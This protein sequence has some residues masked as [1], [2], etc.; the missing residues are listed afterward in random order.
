M[1]KT[2]KNIGELDRSLDLLNSI[3]DMAEIGGWELDTSNGQLFWT[4]GVYNIYGIPHGTP[5]DKFDGLSFYAEHDRPRITECVRLCMEEG[6][7]YD[8]EFD[9]INQQGE[10]L[11]V[12]AMGRPIYDENQNIVFLRGSFQDITETRRREKELKDSHRFLKSIEDNAAHALISGGIDGIILS[13]SKA[14]EEMLGYSA[15]EMIGIQTPA[16]FH[17]LDE[18]VSRSIEFSKKLGRKIEPGFETFICHSD[19]GLKNQFEWTYIHKDGTKFPVNL[20]ITILRDE[21]NRKIGY[22]G[23]AEDLREK[24]KLENDLEEE[25]LKLLQSSKLATLGEMAAGVAHEINNPLM[26]ISGCINVLRKSDLSET[27]KNKNIEMLMKSIKRITKIVKGLKKFSRAKDDITLEE[28]KVVAL[29]EECLTL[30][31][32]KSK[33]HEVPVKSTIDQEVT[34]FI[35][36]V[37]LEQI[38]VNLIG[39]AI[40]ANTGCPDP[41]VE[42][43][44][45]RTQSFD[46]IIVIDSGKGVEKEHLDKLY[47]PFFTTKEIGKGTGLGLSISS[48]IAKDHGGKLEYQF[49]DGHT[50]FVLSLPIYQAK[51]KIA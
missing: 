33:R 37:H 15:D 29:V 35:D 1:K 5:M 45:N 48:G 12:R 38:L 34:L 42:L 28:I 9:F 14:A 23:I 51:K 31:E 25:R 21:D 8:Q 50:A 40:D 41:W 3:Q 44:Y 46:Q 6:L 26:I 20:T 22:L 17:D 2:E 19:E 11:V 30:V 27:R 13:F 18:V 7:A 43:R 39:N 49:I 24:K 10:E 32:S 47:D 16:V 36:E 4:K